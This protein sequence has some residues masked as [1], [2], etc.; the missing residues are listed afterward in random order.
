VN[1]FFDGDG[2]TA[3]NPI[4]ATNAALAATLPPVIGIVL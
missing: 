1:R 3:G 4:I 2:M